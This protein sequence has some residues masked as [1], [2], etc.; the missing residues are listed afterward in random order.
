M[1]ADSF[2]AMPDFGPPQDSLRGLASV[3]VQEDFPD[4]EYVP[5]S[6]RHRI[7]VDEKMDKLDSEDKEEPKS[8]FSHPITGIALIGGLTGL[9][10]IAAK[11]IYD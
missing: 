6:E 1:E 10:F 3:D 11:G 4:M 5:L 8:L 2:N 7:E 9:F